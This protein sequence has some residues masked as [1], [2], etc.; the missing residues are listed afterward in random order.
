[1]NHEL[2][3]WPKYFEAIVNG[4]K[5]FEIRRDDRPFA[6]GDTLRLRE[7]D[8]ST[9]TFSGRFVDVVVGFIY[10]GPWT[11]DGFA[12]LGVRLLEEVFELESLRAENRDLRDS[13]GYAEYRAH[14]ASLSAE[15]ERS[16]RLRAE[17]D[18][19]EES[20]IRE[21]AHRRDLRRREDDALMR[22]L[23]GRPW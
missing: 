4:S 15:R 23:T 5:T 17:S 18:A 12:V 8:P 10:R 3:T 19:R 7:F 21:A 22:R 14:E 6:E 1:M 16:D 9:S 20:A 2:K 13:L 11:K